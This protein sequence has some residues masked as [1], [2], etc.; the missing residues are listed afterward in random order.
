MNMYEVSRLLGLASPKKLNT[1]QRK[2]A[3]LDAVIAERRRQLR[4]YRGKVALAEKL[5]LDVK[6][7]R[8][9]II[10][11][12][13]LNRFTGG[14][15]SGLRQYRRPEVIMSEREAVLDM[16]EAKG[17]CTA[18]DVAK[19][20]PGN[21]ERVKKWLLTTGMFDLDYIPHKRG[22]LK[23][24]R[25]YT[26]NDKPR[27]KWNPKGTWG[28]AYARMEAGVLDDNNNRLPDNRQRIM[29]GVRLARKLAGATR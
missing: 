12:R 15:G 2:M 11:R 21:P 10:E 28:K 16:M 14:W 17:V 7:E 26:R 5:T 4:I 29:G 19:M 3:R 1:M 8:K 6:R 22:A 25:R 13:A 18:S 23:K 20:V 24:I 9:A 27:V